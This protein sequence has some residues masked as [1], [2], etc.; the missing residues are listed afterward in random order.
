MCA[1]NYTTFY[2]KGTFPAGEWAK[3]QEEESKIVGKALGFQ[4]KEH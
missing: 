2:H 4:G 1:R 3:D